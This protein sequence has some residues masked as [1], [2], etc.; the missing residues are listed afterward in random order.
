M[1]VKI[2]GLEQL[3]KKMGRLAG[4]QY[5]KGVMG[6]AAQDVMNYIAQYPPSTEANSPRGFNTV[7]SISTRKPTNR[8]YQRGYGPRWQRKDGSVG[9]SKTSEMLGRKWRSKVDGD[10]MRAVVSNKASYG[11]FVQRAEEQA[12]FHKARGW[13]TDA[14]AIARQLPITMAKVQ[15]AIMQAW[16]K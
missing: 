7:S 11:P 13:R 3:Q 2:E 12:S 14:M 16:S 8:W 15:K 1:E 5:M 6:A 4:A 10:G 9:G